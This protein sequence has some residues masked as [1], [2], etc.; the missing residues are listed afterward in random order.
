MELLVAA[1]VVTLMAGGAWLQGGRTIG[2]ANRALTGALMGQSA[3]R[4]RWFAQNADGSYRAWR[5]VAWA[6]LAVA[7]VLAWIGALTLMIG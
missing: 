6:L 2:D 1:V 7:V 3:T 4:S 5:L